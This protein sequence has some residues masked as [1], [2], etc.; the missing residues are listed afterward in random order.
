MNMFE[1]RV[2]RY[3]VEEDELAD[4]MYVVGRYG[5]AYRVRKEEKDPERI[6]VGGYKPTYRVHVYA[7]F[8]AAYKFER[9]FCET[10]EFNRVDFEW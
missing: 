10:F 4:F 7:P 6:Y 3:R 8:W 1:R 5:F 2:C 9:F